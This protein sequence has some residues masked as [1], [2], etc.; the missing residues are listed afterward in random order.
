MPQSACVVASARKE[1]LVAILTK[2]V[3]Q[4]FDES[5]IDQKLSKSSKS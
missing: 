4:K 3:R 1:Q 5:K 2:A